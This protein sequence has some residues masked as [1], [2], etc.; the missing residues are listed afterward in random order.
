MAL[1]FFSSM[2]ILT[3]FSIAG[4]KLENNSL[5]PN[6]VD[7]I[8]VEKSKRQI[9]LY[10]K[11]E[12]VKTYKIS[13]GKN[14]IGHKEKQG[15]FKTPEGV[16]RVSGKNPNSRFHKSLR[17]SYPNEQDIIC[18]QNNCV[19]PGGDIMIH[20]L[21]K[22]SAWIGKDHVQ[23]D[24][25]HGCIAVSNDEMDEIYQLTKVNAAIEIRA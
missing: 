3:A 15:D 21:D 20:G 1:R 13:L 5:K 18:A 10:C 19:N 7:R 8:L 23:N 6:S 4:P 17:V 12:I 2:L 11:D 22:K 16:Y 24:W 25:T 14:P 9:S